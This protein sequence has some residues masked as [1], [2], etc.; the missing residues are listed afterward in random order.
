MTKVLLSVKMRDVSKSKNFCKRRN[1][2]TILQK[3]TQKEKGKKTQ[4]QTC[5]C[6]SPLPVPCVYEQINIVTFLPER[7]DHPS[8][9][10]KNAT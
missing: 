5:L 10:T 7:Y 9:R 2:G 8:N 1:L 6:P 3:K 4:K